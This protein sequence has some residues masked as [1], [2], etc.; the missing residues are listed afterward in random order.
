MV[1]AGLNL[2]FRKK[3]Q[4]GV[5]DKRYPASTDLNTGGGLGYGG[6]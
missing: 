4:G 1:E 3:Y 5:Q 6:D 2:S